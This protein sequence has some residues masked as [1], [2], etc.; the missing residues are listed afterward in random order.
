MDVGARSEIHNII[1]DLAARGVSIIVISS[2]VEEL[3]GLCDRVMVMSEGKIA[4]Y[5]KGQE[6][7]KEAIIHLSYA[8]STN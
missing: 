5:L 8:H 2:E 7:T 3:P 6:I 4:G 1:R